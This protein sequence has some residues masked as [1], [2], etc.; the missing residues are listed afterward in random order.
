MMNLL[1]ITFTNII[2]TIIIY[3]VLL[4]TMGNNLIYLTTIEK[5][6]KLNLQLTTI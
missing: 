6:I 5:Y 4:I 3:I 1:N 2:I